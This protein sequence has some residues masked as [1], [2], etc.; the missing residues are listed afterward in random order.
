MQSGELTVTGK[1]STRI[2]LAGRPR[3]VIVRFKHEHH[4]V[5]C[6]PHHHDL[7]EYEVIFV[8]ESP[9]EHHRLGHHHH[10]RLFYLVIRWE[11]SGMR[12]IDWIVLG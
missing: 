10:D 9:R 6:N 8:D 4:H 3:E 12:E 1:D 11:V 7:L 2:L 5:P